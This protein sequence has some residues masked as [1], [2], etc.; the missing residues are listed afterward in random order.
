MGAILGRDKDAVITNFEHHNW[1]MWAIFEGNKPFDSCIDT[2]QDDRRKRLVTTLTAMEA[3]GSTQ[4]F[5]VRYYD[6][7]KKKPT[8]ATEYFAFFPFKV[9]DSEAALEKL[10]AKA[11]GGSNTAAANNLMMMLFEQKLENARMDFRHELEKK[12][13]EMRKLREEYEEEDE[14]DGLGKIGAITNMIGAAGEKY[15]WLQ[16]PIKNLMGTFNNLGNGLKAKYHAAT[17]EKVVMNGVPPKPTEPKDLQELLSWSQKA[18]IQIYREK[19]GVKFNDKSEVI[20]TPENK[21]AMDRADNLYVKD[22]V[23]LA[24]IASTKPKT[25]NST[26]EALREM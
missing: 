24:E 15:K 16:D 1:P 17:E 26:I 3:S 19:E 20:D 22:M 7:L 10:Q 5:D 9:N 4:N 21:E 25:F 23:K 11:G 8:L 13:D 12:E 6:E 2:D 18:L 14:D